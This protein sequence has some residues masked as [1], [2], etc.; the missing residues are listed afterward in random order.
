M[1]LQK[2]HRDRPLNLQTQIQF[3]ERLSKLLGKHYTIKQALEFMHF[4]HQLDHIANKFS[5]LLH[6]G[7]SIDY[8]F[9]MLSF[10]PLIISYINFSKESSH[11][12]D[13][14]S[15]CTHLMKLR[16]N[17]QSKLK[18]TLRYPLFLILM[19][20]MLF[21][22]LNLYLFPSMVQ[23]FKS[24]GETQSV[25]VINTIVFIFNI[26]LVLLVIVALATLLGAMYIRNSPV[27][28]RL[29]IIEK[30][31]IYRSIY[32]SYISIQ[33]SYQLYALL[34]SGK[35]IKDSLILLKTQNEN[36]T[37][38]YFATITLKQLSNG[39]SLYHSIKDFPFIQEDLKWVI[40]RSDE[41]GTLSYD[42]QQYSL[43]LLESLEERIK[44][45]IM[46]I[47]PVLYA[48]V[49]LLVVTVYMLTIFPIYKLIQ[50]I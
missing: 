46:L 35:N 31:P 4:D 30:I 22:G 26:T 43:L 27:E 1:D 6:S 23:T 20:I 33:F 50:Q 8:C 11:L 45:T 24:F 34:Q 14:L 7:H 39:T 10:H 44:Q 42:L 12:H 40:N 17:L 36:D 13:H 38:K 5:L 9:K 41:Q 2:Y 37:L 25:I 48:I 29:M 32:S 15:H 49:G 47:Q 18:K 21:I 19:T 3:I 16:Y 28:K